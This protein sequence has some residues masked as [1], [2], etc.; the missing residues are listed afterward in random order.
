MTRKTKARA[1]GGAQ[2]V[3]VGPYRTATGWRGYA[4]ITKQNEW[5]SPSAILAAKD[6]VGFVGREKAWDAARRAS[7]KCQIKIQ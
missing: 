6:F 5:R 4:T 7:N 2:L 1:E 3:S